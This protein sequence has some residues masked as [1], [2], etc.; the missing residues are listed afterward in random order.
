MNFTWFS[1]IDL[2]FSQ[3]NVWKNTS[4]VFKLQTSTF[5]IPTPEKGQIFSESLAI[6][7][8]YIYLTQRKGFIQ[9]NL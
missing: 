2:V 5:A 4:L 8:K 6:R 7:P 3:R 1:L 9:L